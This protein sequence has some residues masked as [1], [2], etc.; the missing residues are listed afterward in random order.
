V[1][2]GYDLHVHSNVSDGAF[3]PAEV[4]RRAAAA[5]LAGIALC[6]HD[7]TAG[8]ED[9]RAEGERIGLEVILGCELSAQL[10]GHSVHMLAYN[11]DAAH[12]RWVEELQWIR[13]DREVRAAAIVEKLN[14]AGVPITM[15]MVH[16]AAGGESIG[17]PHIAAAMVSIGVIE[18]TPQAFT[19]AWIADGGA[20]YVGKRVLD[21]VSSVRLIREAG[22]VCVMAHPVWL[23]N[24]GFDPDQLIDACAAAGMAGLEVRHPEHG[25]EDQARF[26]R[27]ADELGL[28]ATAASDFHGNEHGGMM[29]VHRTQRHALD[30]LLSRRPASDA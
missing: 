5:Q 6:D 29:G 7:S 19:E 9:A 14:A 1:K 17:R 10:D 12:P 25:P 22:G 21:P 28:I 26:Q 3:E 11:M 13:D 30:E 18:K 27:I 2:R 4:V 8:Y 20:C 23:D 15:E 24:G 16:A